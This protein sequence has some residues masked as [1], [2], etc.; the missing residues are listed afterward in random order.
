MDDHVGDQDTQGQ[1][2]EEFATL[3]AE[4]QDADVVLFNGAVYR[5]G[6]DQIIEQFIARRRRQNVLLILVTQGGNA[7]SAYRLARYLQSNYETFMLYVSGYCK[8]AGTL[9]A[10]GA[11]EI[12]MSEF[13]ELGPLD[14][15][16]SKR[17]E[18]WESQSGLAVLDTLTSLQEYALSAFVGILVEIKRGSGGSVSLK[19][20]TEIATSITSGLFAPIYGQVDPLHVGEAG[21]AMRIATQYGERLLAVG[22]NI[23]RDALHHIISQYPSHEFVIDRQEAS[24]LF[25]SVR[26]PS[27]DESILAKMLG[28]KAH[29]PVNSDDQALPITQFLS[30]ELADAEAGDNESSAA[31]VDHEHLADTSKYGPPGVAQDA[32]SQSTENGTGEGQPH[33]AHS[34]T[35]Q[36]RASESR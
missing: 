12:I 29:M 19:M 33:E 22:E 26:S 6:I 24:L 10:T 34:I 8:S 25:E 5:Q 30:K 28:M 36:D 14:V 2:V 7:D 3:I 20:A 35:L 9:I 31:G 23:G 15:Q 32:L 21:R 4:Q 11:H 16:M 1:G 13:G 17:D 18:L 27:D